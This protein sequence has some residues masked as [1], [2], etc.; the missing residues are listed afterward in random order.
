MSPSLEELTYPLLPS[1]MA[2]EVSLV[3]VVVVVSVTVV[4]M[5]LIPV[6]SWLV[7][8]VMV[9]TITSSVPGVHKP[10]VVVVQSAFILE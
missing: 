5:V 10:I 6:P 2:P 4:V 1:K 7:S 9:S 3:M 8:S